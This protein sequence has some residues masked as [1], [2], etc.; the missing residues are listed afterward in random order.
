MPSNVGIKRV[1]AWSYEIDCIECGKHQLW[2]GMLENYKY[3]LMELH[4][5]E[6]GRIKHVMAY[7]CSWTCYV[8][9]LI[10]ATLNKEKLDDQDV[11]LLMRYKKPVP[12][13][14]VSRCAW[15]Y[16]PSRDVLEKEERKYLAWR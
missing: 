10:K 15:T 11:L 6:K 12:W 14:R 3:R 8:K 4:R 16:L 1:D 7:T 13:D 5:N 2:V 9:A